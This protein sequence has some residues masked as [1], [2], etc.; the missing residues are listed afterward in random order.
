MW[1]NVRA[2]GRT[3]GRGGGDVRARSRSRANEPFLPFDP[4]Q[5]SGRPRP[6]EATPLSTRISSRPEVLCNA[7]R[8]ARE[9]AALCG[10]SRYISRRR[11]V[12]ESIAKVRPRP[13][14]NNTKSSLIGQPR[15][16]IESERQSVAARGTT[17]GGSRGQLLRLHSGE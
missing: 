8:R 6:L 15:N 13:G 3:D 16:K 2:A 17:F 14:A 12:E 1:A 5:P 10:A 11:R 4:S 7:S 9:R